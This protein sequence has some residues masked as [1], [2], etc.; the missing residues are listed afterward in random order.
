VLL[1]NRKDDDPMADERNWWIYPDGL[2][3]QANAL[4][5]NIDAILALTRKRHVPATKVAWAERKGEIARELRRALGLDPWPKKT[6]LNARVTG[7]TERDGYTIENVVFE[8]QPNFYVTANVC[9][10]KGAKPPLPAVVVAAG[11][12]MEQGKNYDMYRTVQLSL[13]RLGFL[14]LAYDPIGQGERRRRG[15][16][17]TVGFAALMTGHLNIGYMAWDTIR[18][19]DYLL[20]R[21][22][23]DPK[24]IGL[25]GNSGGGLN[26]MYAFPVEA[27]FAAAASYGFA[28][29]YHSWIKDGGNHC[30]WSHLPGSARHFEQFEVIGLNVPRPFL[31]GNGT[32]DTI[33][34]KAG[35]LSTMSRAKRIYALH[36]VEDRIAQRLGPHGHGFYPPLR[37]SC[38]GWMCRWLQGKGDGSPVPEAKLTLESWRSKHLR[39]FRDDVKRPKDARTYVDLVREEAAR[40]IAA[41]PPVP[42]GRSGYAAWAKGLRERLWDTLGGEPSVR[43]AAKTVG[44]FRPMTSN[45]SKCRALP[46]RWLQMQ[47]FPPSLIHEW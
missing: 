41:Y 47:W 32:Q 24:R 1:T 29:S 44:T 14:V 2:P 8:S 45:C 42:A 18:A 36:G 17:H 7:R 25:T 30:I 3:D 16:S 46:G 28:C 31:A 10:P 9:V 5:F 11:H 39:C 34:P 23:V 33:F 4:R 38:Y 19:L 40:L 20:T 37:E 12:A 21:K 27:R 13:C 15:N 26:T 22:E 35:F 6:P 43:P